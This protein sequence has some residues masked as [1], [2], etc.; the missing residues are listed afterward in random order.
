[1]PFFCSLFIILLSTLN[2]SN[3]R[4]SLHRQKRAG[5]LNSQSNTKSFKRLK[6]K[7]KQASLLTKRDLLWYIWSK[8]S[9]FWPSTNFVNKSEQCLSLYFLRSSWAPP[10]LQVHT[11]FPVQLAKPYTDYHSWYLFPHSEEQWICLLAS[12]FKSY[13]ARLRDDVRLRYAAHRDRDR[14]QRGPR[15]RDRE[16]ESRAHVRLNQNATWVWRTLMTCVFDL[17]RGFTTFFLSFFSSLA[18]YSQIKVPLWFP[19]TSAS[20]DSVTL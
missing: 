4:N 2:F 7:I 1:M 14:N 11:Q 20:F 13:M 19:K 10:K 18:Y 3:F 5:R 9:L 16:M 17:R 8:D 12:A 15:G 6:I